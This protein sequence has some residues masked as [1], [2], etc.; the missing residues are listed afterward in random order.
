[1]LNELE[2]KIQDILLGFVDMMYALVFGLILVQLY[3]KLVTFPEAFGLKVGKVLV[4]AGVFYFLAWDWI[5]GR[6]LTIR[7]PYRGYRRFFIEIL[8]AI[9]GYGAALFAVANDPVFLLYL[10]ATLQLGAWWAWEADH[11]VSDSADRDE[12][13]FISLYQILVSTVVFGI[14][15]YWVSKYGHV[16]SWYGAVII[17]LAGYAFV[18]SYELQ[19]ERSHGL[20][21]GPGVPFLGRKWVS[22][23]RSK[24]RQGRDK[25]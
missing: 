22:R 3:D 25:Q 15:H 17:T 16:F 20:T 21:G 4:V 5:H 13:R 10:M 9:S 7:N 23:I 14:Y 1:M 8:I 24:T 18:L 6:I 19:F 2:Q 11:E 12:L